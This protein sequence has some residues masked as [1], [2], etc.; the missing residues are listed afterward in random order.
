MSVG[1]RSVCEG[2]IC[3][4]FVV[5]LDIVWNNRTRNPS[6]YG[7]RSQALFKKKEVRLYFGEKLIKTRMESGIIR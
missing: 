3:I 6:S 4:G 1:Q 5:M 7:L 2:F